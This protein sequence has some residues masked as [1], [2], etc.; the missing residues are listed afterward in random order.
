M[1]DNTDDKRFEKCV[2]DKMLREVEHFMLREARLLDTEQLKEWYEQMVSPEIRYVVTC[3]QLRNRNERRYTLPDKVYIYDD[4][5][6]QLG[7]RVTQFYDPQHWRVDPPEQYCRMVTNIEAFE[8]DN[9]DK[10]FVRSNCLVTRAR[11]AYEV[12]QFFYTREDLL[13]RSEQGNLTLLNRTI[14]YPERS[15]QGRNMLILL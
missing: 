1:S 10:I 9:K 11:R 13:I 3:T 2:D 14:D 6:Q 12:D 15:V 8:T 4:N 7:V 5:Y